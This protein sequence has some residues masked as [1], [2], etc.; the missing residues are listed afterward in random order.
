M[1]KPDFDL[2]DGGAAFKLDE[3]GQNV[4]E[5]RCTSWERDADT[6]REVI[7]YVVRTCKLHSELVEALKD[8]RHNA[9]F[10]EVTFKAT[11]LSRI[12]ALLAKAEA[13]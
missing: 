12:D 6:E 4:Y 7:A 5:V 10:K 2:V 9:Q 1:M 3:N 8:F 11:F 13:E